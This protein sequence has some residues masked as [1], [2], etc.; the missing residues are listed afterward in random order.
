MTVSRSIE[1]AY[2]APDAETAEWFEDLLRRIAMG[3]P[4]GTWADVDALGDPRLRQFSNQAFMAGPAR[5]VD[6]ALAGLDGG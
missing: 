6:P 5:P 2:D 3:E 1:I 4:W